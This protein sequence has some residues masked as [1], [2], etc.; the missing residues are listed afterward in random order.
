MSTPNEK[1]CEELFLMYAFMRVYRLRRQ[2]M[3]IYAPTLREEH[4]VGYDGKVDI[5]CRE[6]YLQFKRAKLSTHKDECLGNLYFEINREQLETLKKNYPH[7]SAFYIVGTFIDIN[8]LYYAQ[9]YT[10]VPEFLDRYIAIPAHL[11]DSDITRVYFS[12]ILDENSRYNSHNPKLTYYSEKICWTYSLNRELKP[13]PHQWLY[14]DEIMKNFEQ[15]LYGA[16]ITQ[17][18]TLI[19][20]KSTKYIQQHT[21][22]QEKY[23]LH[24]RTQRDPVTDSQSF[25]NSNLYGPTL[26]RLY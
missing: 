26:M 7:Y 20:R 9:R 16:K 8:Q 23:P 14:G 17:T 19:E 3:V 2:R 21:S 18:D 4:S 6:I 5:G 12:G 22:H 15:G 1:V 10:R 25:Q 13:K 11:I 24:T